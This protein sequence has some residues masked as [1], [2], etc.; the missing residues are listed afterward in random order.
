MRPSWRSLP[1]GRRCSVAAKSNGDCQCGQSE[2]QQPTSTAHCRYRH[3]TR[4]EAAKFS[5]RRDLRL[6][7]RRIQAPAGAIIAHLLRGL[8]VQ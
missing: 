3:S 4:G 7:Q 8:P 6:N 5:N 2:R 1:L